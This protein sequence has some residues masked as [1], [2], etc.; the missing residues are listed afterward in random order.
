MQTHMKTRRLIIITILGSLLHAASDT[1]AQGTAFTYQGQLQSGGIPA[2]GSYDMTF[3]L[4]NASSGGAQVGP[5][6]TDL[7]LGVTNGLFTALLDFGSVFNGT[8]YWLQI[9]VR[10]NGVV[11]YTPLSPREELTPT[12]YAITAENITGP[13]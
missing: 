10:T 7:G 11:S 2:N 1:Y 13:V 4:Y 9:G 5:T 6:L 12:P 8:K 3:A